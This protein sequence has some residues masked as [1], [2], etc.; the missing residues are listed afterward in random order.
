[1]RDPVHRIKPQESRLIPRAPSR[2]RGTRFGPAHRRLHQRPPAEDDENSNGMETESR[3]FQPHQSR[4]G[5]RA[6]CKPAP[7]SGRKNAVLEIGPEKM[8]VSDKENRQAL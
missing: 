1:M 5:Q 4:D 7:I 8:K 2:S 6:G 3:Y